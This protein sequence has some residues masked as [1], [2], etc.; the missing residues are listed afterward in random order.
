MPKVGASGSSSGP[1]IS[2]AGNPSSSAPMTVS[3]ITVASMNIVPEP[4]SSPNKAAICCGIL[5]N[6]SDHEN[7]RAVLVMNST[8]PACA[9]VF[10]SVFHSARRDQAR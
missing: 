5:A 7:V 6:V 1:K 2:N 10:T 4:L 8:M 9:A 3:V